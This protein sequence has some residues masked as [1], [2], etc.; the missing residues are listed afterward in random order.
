[1]AQD[2]PAMAEVAGAEVLEGPADFPADMARMALELAQSVREKQRA[3]MFALYR[4]SEAEA[5]MTELYDCSKTFPLPAIA[6]LHGQCNAASVLGLWHDE[7]LKEAL[8]QPVL[9]FPGHSLDAL[10]GAADAHG[11]DVTTGPALCEHEDFAGW[12]TDRFRETR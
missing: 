1:M 11:L 8:V 4:L 5:L 10:Q 7:G 2:V 6:G 9:L 3:V 12:L